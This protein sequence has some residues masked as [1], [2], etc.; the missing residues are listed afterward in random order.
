MELVSYNRKTARMKIFGLDDLIGGAIG[1]IGS[2]VSGNSLSNAYKQATNKANTTLSDAYAN[3]QNMY[4]PY[5]NG[6]TTAFNTLAKDVNTGTGVS[7][8]FTMS[9]F[10]SD[11]GYQFT[12]NQGSS[13]VNNSAAAKG[14]LLS[15]NAAR[16]LDNYTTGLANQTYDSAYGRYL[17]T[18]Q[19][20]YN[21]LSGVA[22][23]G[24]NATNQVNNANLTTAQGISNNYLNGLSAAANANASG[25]VGALNSMGGAVSSLPSTLSSIY[26]NSNLRRAQG[27]A[28]QGGSVGYAG[29]DLTSMIGDY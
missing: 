27:L 10:Y 19:Q 16:S 8:P 2:I 17:S 11:P 13:A 14:G 18:R 5:V 29:S 26:M 25:Y 22:N 6:G 24:L 15:G 1:G 23:M 28:A 9:N 20:G 7:A 12:L 3:T 4:S 21:E